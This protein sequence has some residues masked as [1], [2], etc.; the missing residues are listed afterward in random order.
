MLAHHARRIAIFGALYCVVLSS[1]KFVFLASLIYFI[2][3][4]GEL[5]NE[6]ISAG[7]LIGFFIAIFSQFIGYY[8]PNMEAYERMKKSHPGQYEEDLERERKAKGL[9]T[10]VE[11]YWFIRK[12]KELGSHDQGV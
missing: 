3:F 7:L 5:S 9:L 2:F 1:A 12:E 4:R 10:M 11:F 6:Q 8:L